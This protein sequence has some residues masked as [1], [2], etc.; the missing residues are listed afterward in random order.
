MDTSATWRL[1]DP[2]DVA[3]FCHCCGAPKTHG[4]E[5]F[6]DLCLGA[7]ESPPGLDEP[8]PGDIWHDVRRQIHVRVVSGYDTAGLARA[9]FVCEAPLPDNGG[10]RVYFAK[11]FTNA[12]GAPYILG[13]RRG[14]VLIGHMKRTGNV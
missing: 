5:M 11:D 14:A 2:R 7:T 10:R 4:R 8:V 9:E 13:I 1:L 6:C 3:P 12:D